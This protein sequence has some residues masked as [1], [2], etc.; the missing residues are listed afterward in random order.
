MRNLDDIGLRPQVSVYWDAPSPLLY[1]ITIRKGLGQM[2]NFGALVVDTTPYTGRSP[3]DKFVVREPSIESELWWGE[4]N[5]PFEP[6]PGQ[7][8]S[9]KKIGPTCFS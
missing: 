5:Q 6:E 8:L 1:E 7:F 9:F 2:S 3:K 4:V